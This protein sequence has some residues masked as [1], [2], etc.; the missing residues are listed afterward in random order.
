METQRPLV[1]TLTL[2]KKNG[3]GGMRRPDFWPYYKVAVLKT[4]GYWHKA[5]I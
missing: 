2:R 5:E 1:A 4:T 3:A